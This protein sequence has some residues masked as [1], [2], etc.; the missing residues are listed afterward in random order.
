MRGIST[1]GRTAKLEETKA[2]LLRRSAADD[3]EA[4]MLGFV[5]P[6]LAG[7]RLAG[8]CGKARRDKPAGRVRGDMSGY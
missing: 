5:Q 4:V 8:F 7:R 6:Q 3:P 1:S 2:Q